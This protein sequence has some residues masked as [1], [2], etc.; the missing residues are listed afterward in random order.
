MMSDYH[1]IQIIKDGTILPES[2][3]RVL[4]CPYSKLDSR[5]GYMDDSGYFK[6]KNNYCEDAA[7][8]FY[9]TDDRGLYAARIIAGRMR[10]DGLMEVIL[11]AMGDI[12]WMNITQ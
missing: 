11:N 1:K 3:Y 5:Y 6:C 12:V 10:S 7:C 2:E 4:R 9:H 8:T